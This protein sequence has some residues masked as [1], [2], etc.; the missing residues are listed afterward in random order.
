MWSEYVTF[1][2]LFRLKMAVID[3]LLAIGFVTVSLAS[4]AF[5]QS[6]AAIQASSPQQDFAC[7]IKFPVE[8][9]FLVSR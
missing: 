2:L 3:P 9:L 7:L 6:L 8:D 4:A 1:P 5:L